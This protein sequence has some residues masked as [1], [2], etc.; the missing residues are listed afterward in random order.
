[1]STPIH[2]MQRLGSLEVNFE[3]LIA[4]TGLRATNADVRRMNA[5]ENVISRLARQ[6][7]DVLTLI[8]PASDLRLNT[9]TSDRLLAWIAISDSNNSR[10]IERFDVYAS[11]T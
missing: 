11:G 6:W 4:A 3:W 2:P 7:R 5:V 9:Q 10:T 1:M 8:W